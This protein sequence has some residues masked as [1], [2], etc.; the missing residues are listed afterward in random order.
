MQA[1]LAITLTERDGRLSPRLVAPGSSAA[2]ALLLGRSPEDAVEMLG[3]LFN[4]CRHAQ[5]AA[6][7][8]AFG[9]PLPAIDGIR[10]EI[11]RDTLFRLFIGLP[12]AMGHATVPL[13]VGWQDDPKRAA[14]ALFG[15]AGRFPA[16]WPAF[17]DWL[18]S[19]AGL[20]PLVAALSGTFAPGEAAARTLP[21]ASGD[22]LP[23]E[24]SAAMRHAGHPVMARIEA[25]YG[26]GP[27]WRTVARML[28]ADAC[29]QG[30]QPVARLVAPG[31]AEAPSARGLYRIGVSVR[32]GRVI[33]IRRRT[34]TD[35]FCHPDGAMVS[36]LAALPIAKRHLAPLV[37]E[38]F[39]PCMPWAVQEMADA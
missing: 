34:P 35:D 21:F 12:R 29:F 23:C 7:R 39:D 14:L 9:L 13:P 18:S 27:L 22:D 30:W 1:R 11:L 33:A 28:D 36:A 31:L 4:L 10:G 26:R 25:D 5:E 17:Q 19:A 38:C 24:N 37:V 16:T 6:A 8:L 32:D 3:R 15:P 2:E 20:A